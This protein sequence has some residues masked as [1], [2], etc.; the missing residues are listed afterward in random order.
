MAARDALGPFEELL[1]EG[2]VHAALAVY[3]AHEPFGEVDPNRVPD[4]FKRSMA[5]I[6]GRN[7]ANIDVVLAWS[8]SLEFTDAKA[9]R[10]LAALVASSAKLLCKSAGSL[11]LALKVAVGAP[12][13]CADPDLVA[14]IKHLIALRDVHHVTLPS[15]SSVLDDVHGAL[16]V[17]LMLQRCA[18]VEHELATHV[19]PWLKL[20]GA[21]FDSVLLE[22]VP[23]LAGDVDRAVQV[24]QHVRD[25]A[26]QA[27]AL[28]ALAR[29][30]VPPYAPALM[31]LVEQLSSHDDVRAEAW[32][33]RARAVAF[34][35]DAAA[36]FDPTQ[37]AHS[38]ALSA[39]IL[40]RLGADGV[41]DDAGVLADALQVAPAF[42][43]ARVGVDALFAASF[44]HV[45]PS[46]A[47][48]LVQLV[49]RECSPSVREATVLLDSLVDVAPSARS[50]R[51]WLPAPPLCQQSAAAA[52]AAL[53]A[54]AGAPAKPAGDAA[55][56]YAAQA[57]AVLVCDDADAL[58][59]AVA[60]LG[61]LALATDAQR[62]CTA[63]S[64]AANS[65][66]PR[67]SAR[68][69]RDQPVALSAKTL[70]AQLTAL[71]RRPC[72]DD[73]D[74]L[75]RSLVDAGA[76]QLALRVQAMAGSRRS[77]GDG[78]QAPSEQR[79]RT[80]RALAAMSAA[81]GGDAD[82]TSAYALC[83]GEPMAEP[84][85]VSDAR[86]L[87]LRAGTDASTDTT[88]VACAMARLLASASQPAACESVAAKAAK[89]CDADALAA[90]L[91]LH[92][93]G[94]DYARVRVGVAWL[95]RAEPRNA[96]WV[97]AAQLVEV[98]ASSGLVRDVFAVRRRVAALLPAPFGLLMRV[99]AL[100]E[101]PEENAA[102][103]LALAV[104]S[105]PLV[106]ASV[107]LHLDRLPSAL[108]VAACARIEAAFPLEAVVYAAGRAPDSPE[109]Q[110]RAARVQTERALA[111]LSSR[112]RD[113]VMSAGSPDR[114]L[115]EMYRRAEEGEDVH[116]A[117]ALLPLSDAAALKALQRAVVDW[118]QEF[119][120]NAAPGAA[121]TLHEASPHETWLA[122][123]ARKASVL[124]RV[125]SHRLLA[126]LGKDVL[127]SFAMQ[128]IRPVK[129][130]SRARALRALHSLGDASVLDEL[131]WAARMAMVE[132]GGLQ[133]TRA[134]MQHGDTAA[135]VS[136]LLRDYADNA[137]ALALAASM[138]CDFALD[139]FWEPVMQAQLRGHFYRDA[140]CSLEAAPP[141]AD[142]G[143]SASAWARVLLHADA[144]RADEATL[145]RL[146]ALVERCPHD[147][148]TL[149]AARALAS[150][151]A[152][153]T[154]EG[155][156]RAV[157]QRLLAG[158]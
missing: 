38:R 85:A 79:Q 149:R 111:L 133:R 72:A 129:E 110:A 142:A 88:S 152:F 141:F 24:V 20:V 3:R 59:G 98:L 132:A 26:V 100:G 114:L 145:L 32:R 120:A 44:A 148:V 112:T 62:A 157:E 29:R 11:D 10:E 116:A 102:D 14:R 156:L 86:L 48:A 87:L 2:R 28:L 154:V 76:A 93:D 73:A 16:P 147:N 5:Q 97:R 68:R 140:L 7:K 56:A 34:K 19:A 27:K 1:K 77:R 146:C 137:V 31:A 127:R 37:P 23:R 155:R 84:Q 17:E 78:D 64:T 40:T 18:D 107:R 118:L 81:H 125:L 96:A 43:R 126:P 46:R 9:R 66:A 105:R 108:A 115:V 70:L 117:A 8:A 74:A 35:Y 135:V 22:C 122:A 82:L 144:A 41:R 58:D 50:L 12:A 52:A 113:A 92:V 91:E 103:A 153:A 54:P 119:D 49:L 51:L 138:A 130:Q 158:V 104:A 6:L 121:Q 57:R 99:A 33:M 109:A 123:Q 4:V 15:S 13:E 139:R 67:P 131:A 143:P 53:S 21:D 95:M 94:S 101:T 75:A 69:F 65:T 83:S 150:K 136:S 90:Q 80:L 151:T 55:A 63:L 36:E 89:V 39:H 128:T 124:V 106:W 30:V 61:K 60:L 47:R 25:D 42:E 71:E 45:A 134:Q